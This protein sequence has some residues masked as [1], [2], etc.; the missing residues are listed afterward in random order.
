MIAKDII[1]NEFGM[2]SAL[3]SCRGIRN[4]RLKHPKSLEAV[5]KPQISFKGKASG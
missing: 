5:S 1:V 3:F 2:F 4:I